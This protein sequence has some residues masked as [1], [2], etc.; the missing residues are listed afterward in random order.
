VLE[1]GERIE[2]CADDANIETTSAPVS[3]R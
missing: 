1:K 2:T 3:V